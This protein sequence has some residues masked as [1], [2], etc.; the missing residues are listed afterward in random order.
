ME[1]ASFRIALGFEINRGMKHL[2]EYKD[3]S[4]WRKKPAARLRV[5]VSDDS[6]KSLVVENLLGVLKSA[7]VVARVV[8]TGEFGDPYFLSVEP[9]I[10]LEE[11]AEG[12]LEG[13]CSV[14]VVLNYSG[15]SE[16]LELKW[17]WERGFC[18]GDLVV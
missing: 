13:D 10:P 2:K 12:L 17:D 16:T 8:Q 5:E 7:G 6:V 11:I 1:G 15:R 3:W 9:A 14:R 18:K 4:W